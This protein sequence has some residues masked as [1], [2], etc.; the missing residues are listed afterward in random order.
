AGERAGRER[1]AHVLL[2][3]TQGGQIE[4]QKRAEAHLH[5]GHE[6]IGPIETATAAVRDFP[7][8]LLPALPMMRDLTA[9]ARGK[10]RQPLQAGKPLRDAA[11]PQAA[12]AIRGASSSTL[13]QR[14]HVGF[15][16]AGAGGATR[17]CDVTTWP[18][19]CCKA[20]RSQTPACR[21]VWPWR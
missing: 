13:S 7:V 10:T 4:R 12:L 1:K 19:N 6:E 5:V 20:A 15:G 11:E 18:A 17:L 9:A 8:P 14:A 3:P 2:R 21:T 16:V